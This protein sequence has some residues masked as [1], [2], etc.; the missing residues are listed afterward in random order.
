MRNLIDAGDEPVEFVVCAPAEEIEENSIEELVRLSEIA[1]IKRDAITGVDSK[2]SCVCVNP[3]FYCKLMHTPFRYNDAKF[4]FSGANK[5][6]IN[7][8][9]ESQKWYQRCM[10]CGPKFDDNMCL[11]LDS[12]AN[13]N[14]FRNKKFLK[15]IRKIEEPIRVVGIGGMVLYHYVGDHPWFGECCFDPNSS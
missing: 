5:N 14:V 7:G 3:D 12:H 13:V 9:Y 11:S 15:N 10:D 2:P 8:I 4:N 6:K 1:I